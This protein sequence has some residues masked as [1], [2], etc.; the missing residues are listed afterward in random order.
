MLSFNRLGNHLYLENC[1]IYESYAS[2]ANIRLN[3]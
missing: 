1:S 3:S 2:S